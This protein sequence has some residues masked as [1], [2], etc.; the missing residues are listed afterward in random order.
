VLR[1]WINRL[2]GFVGRRRTDAD[3]EEELRMHLEFAA[4]DARRR[5]MAPEDAARAATLSA[6][7]VETAI[8]FERD[9]RGLPW[10]DDLSRDLRYAYRTLTRVPAFTA[11][12]VISLALG[13][14]ANS[15]IFTLM[16]AVLFRTLQVERPD[17]L[18]FI[19]HDDG[20]RVELSANY[21]IFERYRSASAFSGVTLYRGRTFRLKVPDGTERM[22]GQYVSGNY[23]AVV[24]APMALGRGF[25]SEVDRRAGSSPIAVISYDCWMR[26]FGGRGDILGAT[27]TL[28]DRPVTVVGVTARGFHGLNP[29][30]RVEVMLPMSMMALD[31]PSFFDATDGWLGLTIVARLAP[32]A[33]E[34]QALAETDA[35]FQ[36][37]LSEPPNRWARRPG[38]DAFRSAALEPAARGTFGL[39]R[40]YAQPLWILMAMVGVLLLVACAN[41]AILSLARASD[42]YGEIAVRLSIGAG[43]SRIVR[44]LLTESAAL[45]VLG[46]IGGV[47]VAIWGT[48]AILSVFAIGPSPAAID[49]AVNL[50]VLAATAA[51]IILTAI[52]FGLVPAIRS[53]RIDLA[54]ALQDGA[55][56]I[57]GARRPTLGKALVVA[58]V[59][60]SLVLVTAAAL[61]SRSLRN[62]HE[63]DAGFTRANVLLADV[64]LDATRLPPEG[65]QRAFSDLLDRVRSLPGV[66]STSLS[67]RTPIDFSSQVR[68]I[69]VP[70]VEASPRNGIS[71]NSVT[72]GYFQT[73]GFTIV[74]GRD[75][76]D[77][78]RPSTAPV[79][80]VSES[81]ARHFFGDA[82]PLGRTFRL[83]MKG[84]NTTIVGV[85]TDSRHEQLRTDTPPRMVY[86][87]LSQMDAGLDGFVNVPNRAAIAV[88]AS[89]DAAAMISNLRSEL[90]AIN[91]DAMLLYVRTME[92]QIDATL[93]PERLLATLSTSFAA[94]ALLL[95]CV[96]LYGVMA[97]NVSRRRREIGLRIALG[98][99]PRAIL[100]RVLREAVTVSAIGIV[101]GLSIALATTRLLSSF[102]FDV[103]PRDTTTLLLTTGVLFAVAIL[104]GFFPARRAAAVDPVGALRER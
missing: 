102:L 54:P 8:E 99:F 13:I 38:T 69:E 100:Y 74:R 7:R 43:R 12:A 28:N 78:D 94:I 35:L 50:R 64:E 45:A 47:L 30:S 41:V 57:H 76:T 63:F 92:Q 79:A 6:G 14:G 53:T 26:R 59:A 96:G 58:Q 34:T 98:A 15:A 82:D 61:L 84:R 21:P 37:F 40:Q 17:R 20:P 18:Y 81:M 16:D 1:E 49:A 55:A 46:G 31:D 72:P 85:V 10:L 9:Q 65:R 104:A 80:V 36:Q 51:L 23:H 29:G 95:A 71:S 19:G 33:S 77:D 86:L 32:G 22:A 93:I 101:L 89:G 42:R 66:R 103:M 11:I 60:L 88:A 73:F 3:L 24:G 75:F 62:L 87:P 48:Q 56:A 5:G 70:G 67:L 97:Y 52:G 27:L 39:R 83:G 25:S 68:R 2:W 44:Q 90:K 4:D 91:R